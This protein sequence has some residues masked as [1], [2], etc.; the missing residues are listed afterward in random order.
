MKAPCLICQNNITSLKKC[1][2]KRHYNSRHSE[3]Y[4]GNLGQLQVD[5]APQ[6]KKSLQGQQKMIS[7]YKNDTQL[8]SEFNFK[9][10]EAIAGKKKS[11]V[12]V[13]SSSTTWW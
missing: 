10:S 7:H 3:Q 5:K 1:N 8:E 11:L 13:S 12:M 4:K 2:V 6:L 9:F